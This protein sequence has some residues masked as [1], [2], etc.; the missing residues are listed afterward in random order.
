MA[1]LGKIVSISVSRSVSCECH[2]SV[3]AIN[4]THI[5]EDVDPSACNEVPVLECTTGAEIGGRLYMVTCE[6]VLTNS[7]VAD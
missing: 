1:G 2:N 3:A 4:D 7:E 5:C 6:D